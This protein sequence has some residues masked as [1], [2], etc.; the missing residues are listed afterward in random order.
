MNDSL[1]TWMG[2]LLGLGSAGLF[3]ASGV[4]KGRVEALEKDLKDEKGRSASLREELADQERRHREHDDEVQIE[5]TEQRRRRQAAEQRVE[6]C[7]SEQAGMRREMDALAKVITAEAHI[8]ALSEGQSAMHQDLVALPGRVAT[9]V[10][11]A[12]GEGQG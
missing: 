3:L 10:V 8:V 1:L 6:A 2:I 4:R 7:I 11:E 5:L 12:I 9:A